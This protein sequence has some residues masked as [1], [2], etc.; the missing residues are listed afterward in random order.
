MLISYFSQKMVNYLELQ[1]TKRVGI[2][3]VLSCHQYR[4][5]Q[6]LLHMV[7]SAHGSTAALH[8]FSLDQRE[9]RN[10]APALGQVSGGY[11]QVSGG[12]L[13]VCAPCHGSLSLSFLSRKH[14]VA[15]QPARPIWETAGTSWTFCLLV[16]RKGNA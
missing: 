15:L 6:C 2:T 9:A 16:G 12:A 10:R 7:E 13:L 8:L 4:N 1:Q 11:Q 3:V 5:V 14:K